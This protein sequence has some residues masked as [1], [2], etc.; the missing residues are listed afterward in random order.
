MVYKMNFSYFNKMTSFID[1]MTNVG[2]HKSS[3][4]VQNK[5][6]APVIID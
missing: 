5:P 4:F 1:I 6:V 2:N 3:N